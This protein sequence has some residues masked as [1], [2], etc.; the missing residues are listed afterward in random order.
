ME[1]AVVFGA[2]LWRRGWAGE[3]VVV[4][5]EEKVLVVVRNNVQPTQI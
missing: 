5:D 2:K 4:D 1:D 3:Y